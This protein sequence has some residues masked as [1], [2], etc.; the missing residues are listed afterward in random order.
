MSAPSHYDALGV[1]PGADLGEIRSAFERLSSV[2]D[3]S[4]LALYA[5]VGAEEGE[6]EARR[7]REAF[8]I[9]SDP[10]SRAEY[11]A[12]LGLEPAEIELTDEDIVSS[13]SLAAASADGSTSPPASPRAAPAQEE[14]VEAT[15]GLVPLT[16][17]VEN[18]D[19]AAKDESVMAVAMVTKGDSFDEAPEAAAT[20]EGEA[21]ADPLQIDPD[22]E[23]TGAL[24]RALRESK[25]FSLKD[26]AGR[27]RIGAGHLHN[28]EEEAF[29]LLPER[30][31]LRGF[32]LSYAREL[33]LDAAR[34]ADTYL[35]R[36]GR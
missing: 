7:I 6:V 15:A 16:D 34:V 21:P 13:V 25:G 30:V 10:D 18:E 23:F 28:I 14:P 5:L 3:S 4:S 19:P 1:T 12:S 27:T 2:F 20:G 26:I 8:R 17:S 35:R 24:L 11:D 22:T 29:D 9:L 31:F 32:L 36:R 33:K